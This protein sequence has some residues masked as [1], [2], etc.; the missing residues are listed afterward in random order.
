MKKRK[1]DKDT[2][3]VTPVA[4]SI[5]SFFNRFVED[6]GSEGDAHPPG[7]DPRANTDISAAGAE[8]PRYSEHP[9]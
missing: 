1:T 8:R 5:A 6:R 4:G 2:D 3:R 9:A 7:R